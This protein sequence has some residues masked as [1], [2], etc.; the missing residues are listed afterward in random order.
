MIRLFI[1]TA[2]SMASLAACSVPASAAAVPSASL[3]AAHLLSDQPVPSP[4]PKVIRPAGHRPPSAVRSAVRRMPTAALARV[5]AANREAVRE[6]DPANFLGAVQVYP[7]SDGA[8]Y[9]LYAAPGEV[10]DLALQP[11]E[12]LVSVAAGDTVR[13]IIGDTSSGSGA[14]RRTHILVKPAAAGLTTNLVIA[15]DRRVYHVRAE[16][17]SRTAMTSIAW[18]YPEDVLLALRGAATPPSDPVAGGLSIEQLNF[19]YR[20]E[21]DSA[22]WR[23][24]RAFDDGR[25]LFIQF[26]PT[27]AQ[28]E[29]PPLFVTGDK[30]RA[31]L[32]NYRIRGRYY[33]VDRLFATAELR[34]G[35]KHQQVVRILR[36]AEA[37]RGGRGS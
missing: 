14:S 32:V 30:G 11:G 17:N 2:V 26:P 18:T 13:W 15:T 19:D 37:R 29:A 4:T 24:I 16:S 1:L 36:G 21:G 23:P 7:W 28:G 33:V 3:L 34:M 22:P 8:L 9:R 31:E 35:G 27:L 20:I 10:S 6:P 12:E 25:Q 5:Q